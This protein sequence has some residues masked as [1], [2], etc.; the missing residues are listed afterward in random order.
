MDVLEIRIRENCKVQI[1][2]LPV[3]LSQTEA[4]KITRII[5]AHVVD[6]PCER[7]T[8]ETSVLIPA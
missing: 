7:R 8:D 2:G 5:R 4:H 6:E 3:D 1:G